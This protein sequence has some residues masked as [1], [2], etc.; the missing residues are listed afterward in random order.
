V[1]SGDESDVVKKLVKR[2]RE[3]RESKG[4]SQYRLA[5]DTGLSPSGLRHMEN[6]DTSP[7]LF[8]LLRIC[9]FLEVDL[10]ALLRE[11]AETESLP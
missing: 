10:P 5:K 4:V 3:I 1:P 7:T 11:A 2:L 9:T 6:G 8:F